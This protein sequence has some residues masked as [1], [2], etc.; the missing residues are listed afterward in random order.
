VED[1]VTGL[2]VPPSDPARLAAAI[3]RLLAD[4]PLRAR[5]ATA[6]RRRFEEHFTIERMV[7]QMIRLYRRLLEPQPA[8]SSI[9]GALA[10]K[11]E[12]RR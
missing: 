6:S 1:G 12:V 2:L 7:Q 8:G 3:E 11:R 9:A 10:T 4:A 5:F